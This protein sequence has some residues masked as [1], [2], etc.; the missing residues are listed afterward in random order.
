MNLSVGVP[1]Y[2][3]GHY[4]AE[5]LDSLL[6]QTVAPQEVV[7]SDNHS[8]DDTRHI[9]RRYEGRI[10]V[11]EPDEHMAVADHWNFVASNMRSEWFAML[12]SDDV[13]EPWYVETLLRQATRHASGVMVR[14]G[15]REVGPDG[16]CY[17]SHRLWSTATLTKTPHNFLEQL[18]GLR[19][20]IASFMCRKSAF[21]E[22]G[23]FTSGM[24]LFDVDLFLRLS[25]QGPFVTTHKLLARKRESH[26]QESVSRRI[27]AYARDQSVIALDVIPRIAANLS[28]P[29][30]D[31]F[32]RASLYRLSCTIADAQV[33]SDPAIRRAVADELRPLASAVGGRPLLDAFE[34][35][36]PIVVHNRF[37][38][39]KRGARA[40]IVQLRSLRDQLVRRE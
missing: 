21:D 16:H 35:G 12:S 10:R 14:G 26:T 39:A 23:G 34:A 27:V 6:R 22:I 3:Q 29:I 18:P 28:L 9:L 8:T 5:T 2:N 32:R 19:S 40:A 11:I 38:K 30:D 37:D 36:R 17:S 25:Q 4:L 7:V 31:A 20:T 1:A 33:I 24:A 15:W 13:A